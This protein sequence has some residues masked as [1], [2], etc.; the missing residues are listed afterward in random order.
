MQQSLGRDD[1]FG[2]EAFVETWAAGLTISVLVQGHTV[3]TAHLSQGQA[4]RLYELQGGDGTLLAAV[5]TLLDA[6]A[7][8]DEPTPLDGQLAMVAGALRFGD[9]PATTTTAEDAGKQAQRARAIADR[10]SR[11]FGGGS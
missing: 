4:Q 11:L 2:Q 8:C 9:A 5:A 7:G 6:W 10:L 3:G 1:T